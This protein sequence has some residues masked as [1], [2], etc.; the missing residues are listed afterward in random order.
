MLALNKKTQKE[1]G[2]GTGNNWLS[3]RMFLLR[4]G[5]LCQMLL[6]LGELRTKSAPWIVW[7]EVI[8]DFVSSLRFMGQ[9]QISLCLETELGYNQNEKICEGMFWEEIWLELAYFWIFMLLPIFCYYIIS[10]SIVIQSR[11]IYS[12]S[13]DSF[14]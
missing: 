12:D 9:M 6:G 8:G 7:Q 2:K 4:R 5:Q 3:S 10:E 14:R 13:Y 11:Y 1:Q